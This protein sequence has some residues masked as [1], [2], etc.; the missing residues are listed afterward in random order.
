[1]KYLVSG[2]L[3]ILF[4]VVLLCAG[5][6]V[7]L[8]HTPFFVKF[9]PNDVYVR[10]SNKTGLDLEEIKLGE[11]M[12]DPAE[13]GFRR[14]TLAKKFKKLKNNEVTEYKNTI[15]QHLGYGSISLYTKDKGGV[16]KSIGIADKYFKEQ[17]QKNDAYV[18]SIYHIYF[19]KNIGGLNLP[20]GKYTYEFQYK[21]E[22][23]LIYV[24]IQKDE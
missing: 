1:M 21:E 9:E 22:D 4:L 24:D 19:N 17:M 18:D 8:F 16:E 6:Y 11:H 20:K 14:K 7:Y 10:I 2:F 3:V 15:G 23:K 13:K 5:M 12:H